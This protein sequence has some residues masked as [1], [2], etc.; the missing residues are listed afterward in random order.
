M[1]QEGNKYKSPLIL[2][3]MQLT[4]CHVR[5]ASDT[6]LQCRQKSM[7]KNR[8]SSNG[9]LGKHALVDSGLVV[10]ANYIIFISKLFFRTMNVL[11]GFLT[12]TNELHIFF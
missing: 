7:P 1:S 8:M 3:V 12:I 9:T 10:A 5:H 2:M 4:R 11:L 6:S